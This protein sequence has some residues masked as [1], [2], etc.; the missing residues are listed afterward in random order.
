MRLFD[1]QQS[2]QHLESCHSGLS[3][4]F[5]LKERNRKDSRQAGM[6]WAIGSQRSMKTVKS[7]LIPL[8]KREELPLF[9]K[10]GWGEITGWYIFGSMT[11]IKEN[12]FYHSKANRIW[13]HRWSD[14]LWF[15][16]YQYFCSLLFPRLWRR[17]KRGWCYLK[18]ISNCPRRT[19]M[20]RTSSL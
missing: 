11:N 6:T 7:L 18:N 14:Q 12:T 10:E 16:L 4:I 20:C 1:T 9:H 5:L 15:S 17:L 2:E 19:W 3:G 8:Y 13:S